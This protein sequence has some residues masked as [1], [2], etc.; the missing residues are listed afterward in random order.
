MTLVIDNLVKR[1][2]VH[3]ERQADDR[4]WEELS[5]RGNLSVTGGID[6]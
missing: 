2:L 4:H 3:R 6:G 5:G 1:G